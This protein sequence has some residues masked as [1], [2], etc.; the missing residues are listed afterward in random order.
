MKKNIQLQKRIKKECSEGSKAFFEVLSKFTT[1]L[2]GITVEKEYLIE[3]C[4]GEIGR[5]TDASRVY[6]FLF[7]NDLEYM[8]NA[9]EWCEKGVSAEKHNLQNLRTELCLWWME[10]LKAN[11]MIVIEDVEEM[12][13]EAE[14]EKEILLEQGIKSLITLPIFHKDHLIGYIGIDNTFQNKKWSIESQ[15][16]L[17]LISEIFSEIFEKLKQ[18][19]QLQY[20]NKELSS[21]E[22][23]LDSFE[24]RSIQQEEMRQYSQSNPFS[25]AIGVNKIDINETIEYVFNTLNCD[26]KIFDKVELNFSKDL[27][28]ILCNRIEISQVIMNILKNAIYEIN[29]KT[30]LFSE[31]KKAV[32][33]SLQIATYQ[34]EGYLI[35]EIED[36]GRGLCD[37]AKCKVFE[38]FFTT[39]EIGVG[40]GLGLAVAYDIITNKY[41]GE[42]IAEDSQWQGAKFTIKLP[43]TQSSESLI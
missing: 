31:Q 13:E 25:Q 6:V 8:D 38:P 29:K 28:S 23:N 18:E 3:E 34:D 9:Y 15:F 17:K 7:R 27:P 40:T 30:A 43:L 33:N 12:P 26:M 5:R 19:K 11:E 36:N 21:R 39:K 42:I 16:L 32:Y 14:V 41:N 35:C 2:N 22:K 37:E 1:K 20:M 24:L 4:L 10:K